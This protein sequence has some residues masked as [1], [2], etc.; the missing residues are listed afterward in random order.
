MDSLLLALNSLKGTFRAIFSKYY[1]S[2]LCF[3]CRIF[4]ICPAAQEMFAKF[5][6]VPFKDLP[7]NENFRS[8]ALQV[9]EA[10]ALG[11][12][13]LNDIESLS[14]ILKDLGAAHSSHGLKDEHFDVRKK[15]IACMSH[16]DQKAW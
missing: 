1:N 16:S 2:Q 6:T 4:T 8:H 15:D 13:S 11:V 12:S 10:I 9:T 3:Y 5:R 7:E 14:V